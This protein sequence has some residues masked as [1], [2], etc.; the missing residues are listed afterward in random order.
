MTCFRVIVFYHLVGISAL[1]LR[2]TRPLFILLVFI[3]LVIL[4][5]GELVSGCSFYLH[6]LDRLPER[7]SSAKLSN[8]LF[9]MDEPPFS[10]LRHVTLIGVTQTGLEASSLD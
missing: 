9:T 2:C 7:P 10:Q 8:L 3:L 1:P 5:G 4:A 6:L